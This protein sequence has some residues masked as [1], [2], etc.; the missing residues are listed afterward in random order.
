MK[1]SKTIPIYKK[2]DKCDVSN[3]RPVSCVPTVS[4]VLESIVLDQLA[5]YFEA[6]SLLPQQQHGFRPGRST[7][8]ALASMVSEWS[9][10]YDAGMNTGILLWDLSSAF[11]TIDVEVLC[12]KLA[13][14]GVSHNS[15]SWIHSFLT[16]RKQIVKVGSSLSRPTF[17]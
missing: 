14:Y 13:L 7:T 3:Y 12:D 6:N 16:Q 8:T 5:E 9:R 2:G 11:D 15:V 4:K 1:N 10:N 17:F